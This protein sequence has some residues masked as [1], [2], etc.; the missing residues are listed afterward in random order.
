VARLAVHEWG[1]DRAPRLVCLHGVTSHGRHFERLAERLAGHYQV[2]APDLIG[3]GDSGYEPPWSIAAQLEAI[4]ETVGDEPAIW[5]GHSYGARLAHDLA[6]RSPELVT[7]LI[8]LDPVIWLPPHV[9]LFAAENGRK[10]RVY[11][12]FEAAVEGRYEESALYAAP[13]A[14][15]EAE[16]ATHLVPS[17]TGEWRY[18]YSQACVIASYSEM[19]STPA[20]FDSVRIPTLLLLG[21]HSYLSYEHLLDE[22]RE[23]LSDLLVVVTVEGGHTV[24]WDCFDETLAAIEGFLKRGLHSA[25]AS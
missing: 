17:D 21:A 4:V 25:P 19:A 7:A 12:S 22:H 14:L 11:A 20:S 6:A 9:A 10:E 13:R 18:R 16:L 24:L 15:L 5:L 1:E 8:H 23:A 2:I 3:H